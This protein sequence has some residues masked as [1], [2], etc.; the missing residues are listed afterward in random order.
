MVDQNVLKE[1][2]YTKQC[3]ILFDFYFWVPVFQSLLRYITQTC[4]S[5]DIS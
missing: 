1:G 3:D 4:M 2:I 5:L